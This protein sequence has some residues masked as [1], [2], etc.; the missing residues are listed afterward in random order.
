MEGTKAAVGKLE[1]KVTKISQDISAIDRNMREILKHLSNVSK[2]SPLES[3]APG[4]PNTPCPSASHFSFDF[5][6]VPIQHEIRQGFACEKLRETKSD[7]RVLLHVQSDCRQKSGDENRPEEF[8]P[9]RRSSL[10]V[11]LLLNPHELVGRRHSDGSKKKNAR[12]PFG[13]GLPVSI[14]DHNVSEK[15]EKEFKETDRLLDHSD[16]VSLVE[17]DL[18]GSYGNIT[19]KVIQIET[20][21]ESCSITDKKNNELN[22]MGKLEEVHSVS[23]KSPHESRRFSE[24]CD[25][26]K[27]CDTDIMKKSSTFDTLKNAQILNVNRD[28]TLP[29]LKFHSAE[30][31]TNLQKSDIFT[32]N[33]KGIF[34]EMLQSSRK[35]KSCV[36]I[37]P[38]PK[39]SDMSSRAK[40][41]DILETEFGAKTPNEV[42]TVHL[43]GKRD[44][45]KASPVYK[46][47][48]DSVHK[49]DESKKD[50]ISPKE[51]CA[52]IIEVDTSYSS[53]WF[54]SDNRATQSASP[55]E[56]PVKDKQTDIQ[57]ELILDDSKADSGHVS[58]LDTSLLD[59]DKEIKERT[60]CDQIVLSGNDKPGE[61]LTPFTVVN[62]HGKLKRLKTDVSPDSLT[63]I[64]ESLITDSV[65]TEDETVNDVNSESAVINNI[66]GPLVDASV[67]RTTDL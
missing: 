57:K 39:R 8:N 15:G 37:S 11:P 58:L 64:S 21:Q 60:V 61:I 45:E 34:L 1:R 55:T 17:S 50:R 53:G 35:S 59:L 63:D 25:T 47:L 22:F 29:A 56:C 14:S 19:D 67:M 27:I 44:I 30:K 48:P 51:V 49:N 20:E 65:K 18:T 12:S 46:E 13:I 7:D 10:Q 26:G 38:K 2:M 66:F 6:D 24:V 33:N 23:C 4:T 31:P 36:E 16:D 52:T 54:K 40:S 42:R 9:R 41:Y 32:N 43:R 28:H 62:S 3:L 5:Q